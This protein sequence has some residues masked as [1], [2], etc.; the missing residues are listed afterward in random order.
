MEK[1]KGTITSVVREAVSILGSEEACNTMLQSHPDINAILCTS[2]RS[3]ISVAQVII[4]RGL[5]GKIMI[6]GA[7]ENGEI[8][9]LTGLLR[10]I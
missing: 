7:D 4:D 10:S 6:I 5:V 3:T 2:A 9:R 1:H 8:I